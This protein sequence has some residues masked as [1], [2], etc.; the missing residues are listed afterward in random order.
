M[1]QKPTV[2]IA[3]TTKEKKNSFGFGKNDTNKAAAPWMGRKS[4]V[5]GHHPHF[6]AKGNGRR[7]SVGQRLMPGIIAN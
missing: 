2:R 5:G 3:Q 4:A 7:T 6:P 1:Y